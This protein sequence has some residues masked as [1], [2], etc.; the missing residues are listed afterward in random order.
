VTLRRRYVLLGAA[1]LVSSAV[2]VVLGLEDHGGFVTPGSIALMV[3]SLAGILLLLVG[4]VQA[5]RGRGPQV[6]IVGA[7][8]LAV[9]WGSLLIAGRIQN[10]QIADAQVAG[11]P[12]AVLPW[13]PRSSDT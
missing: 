5:L 11:A 13:P 7:T 10:R 3:G 9:T 6:L 1:A 12:L 2:L 4:G 8:V